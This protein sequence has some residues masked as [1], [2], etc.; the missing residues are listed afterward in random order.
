MAEALRGKDSL[1]KD[2]EKLIQKE[3]KKGI[4]VNIEENLSEVSD[5]MKTLVGSYDRREKKA[6]KDT[7]QAKEVSRKAI[8]SAQKFWNHNATIAMRQGIRESFRN[9]GSTIAREVSDVLGGDLTQFFYDIKGVIGPI[10]RSLRDAGKMGFDK[11]R[12]KLSEKRAQ[13]LEKDS[14]DTAKGM[15]KLVD[16][17]TRKGSLYTHDIHTENALK[18]LTKGIDENNQ[19]IGS[20]GKESLGF[21]F[22]SMRNSL[23]DI[24]TYTSGIEIGI[25][26]SNHYLKEMW[27]SDIQRFN[28]FE[29]LYRGVQLWWQKWIIDASQGAEKVANRVKEVRKL[30]QLVY[31]VNLAEI[32]IEDSRLRFFGKIIASPFLILKGLYGLF[33]KRTRKEDVRLTLEES[34]LQISL[35]NANLLELIRSDTEIMARSSIEGSQRLASSFNEYNEMQKATLENMKRLQEGEAKRSL[36]GKPKKE[37][38]GLLYSLLAGAVILLGGLLKSVLLPFETLWKAFKGLIIITKLSFLGDVIASLTKNLKIFQKFTEWSKIGKTKIF[39]FFGF[40]AKILNVFEKLP[41]IGKLISVLKFGMK[42]LGWPLIIISSAIDFMKGFSK[43]QG[44]LLDKIKG[45][46]KKAISGF[47]DMPLVLFSKASAFI[48]NSFG[49]NIKAEDI[50]DNMKSWMDKIV[51]VTFGIIRDAASIKGTIQK[52]VEIDELQNEYMKLWIKNKLE[53][54]SDFIESFKISW[55]WSDLEISITKGM[56]YLDDLFSNIVVAKIDKVIEWFGGPKEY[57]NTAYKEDLKKGRERFMAH[58]ME[59]YN[60]LMMEQFAET[61]RYQ[62]IGEFAKESEEERKKQKPWSIFSSS[63]LQ[64]AIDF[65]KLPYETRKWLSERVSKDYEGFTADYLEFFMPEV[66]KGNIGSTIQDVLDMEK[67]RSEIPLMRRIEVTVQDVVGQ[68]GNTTEK[69]F[70]GLQEN[71]SKGLGIVE[72]ETDKIGKEIDKEVEKAQ[73]AGDSI[74]DEVLGFASNLLGEEGPLIKGFLKDLFDNMW[75]KTQQ[76]A[77]KFKGSKLHEELAF[78]MGHGLERLLPPSRENPIPR[79]GSLHSSFGNEFYSIIDSIVKSGYPAKTDETIHQKAYE[80][81][82]RKYPGIDLR[83]PKAGSGAVLINNSNSD[84]LSRSNQYDEMIDPLLSSSI[85]GFTD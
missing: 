42:Y 14:G 4:D 80:M 55:S 63:G 45:G 73:R 37:G 79:F 28:Y 54:V 10:F 26:E 83:S 44:D 29:K 5:K 7:S 76:I 19:K 25:K 57:L 74:I 60:K 27:F 38:S 85:L 49:I 81:L 72:K 39:S 3:L 23:L 1:N 15:K 43:S 53:R 59:I 35:V 32:K 50:K 48:L 20:K 13:N 78:V 30:L 9:A 6:I 77:N 8:E 65:E 33:L 47:F 64:K 84:Y 66:Y 62:K 16:S 68:V 12:G 36:R 2:L 61:I 17:A 11:I 41:I 21:M 67:T 70:D 69:L 34:L 58:S 18:D 56:S 82:Q 24:A 40:F 22:K 75:G 52:A 51:D 31:G 71:V 46:L